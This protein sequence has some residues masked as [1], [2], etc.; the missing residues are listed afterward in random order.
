[1]ERAFFLQ[2]LFKKKRPLYKSGTKQ[3]LL[4]QVRKNLAVGRFVPLS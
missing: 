3:P 4:R 2:A 1:M